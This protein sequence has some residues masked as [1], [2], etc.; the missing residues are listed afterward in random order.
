MNFNKKKYIKAVKKTAVITIVTAMLFT[1]Y[2]CS[3]GVPKTAQRK[4]QQASLI[5]PQVVL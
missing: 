2:G 4:P 5:I 3:S 1:A